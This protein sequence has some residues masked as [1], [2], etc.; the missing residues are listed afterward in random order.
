MKKISKIRWNRYKES[1]QGQDAIALFNQLAAPECT[2]EEMIQAA[3]KYDPQLFYNI[4]EK[5][6]ESLREVID[7]YLHGMKEVIQK[8]KIDFKT[9]DDCLDFYVGVLY[10]TTQHSDDMSFEDI[11][12]GAF[13]RSVADNIFISL[14][15]YNAIGKFF[16]PNFFVM[17]F[18]YLKKFAEK[19]EI[20]L[21]DTPK[22]ADYK[23]RCLFYYDI[24]DCFNEF[25]QENEF[26]SW[27][28]F[29]AFLYD[30]E[31]PEIKEE[32]ENEDESTMPSVPQQAW[33]LVGNYGEGERDMK[34]GFWQ[35]NELTEKGDLLL[36]Y[37]KSP[38]MAMNS[39]WISQTHGVVDPFFARYSNTYIGQKIDIPAEYALT[40][41][42]FKA[43]EYFQNKGSKGNFVS[44]NFQDCSGWPVSNDDFK[45]I[46]RM[47]EAKGFDTSKIP[48][49]YEPEKI[50]DVDIKVEQDV[51]DLR[52][53]PMLEQMG[54]KEGV[55]FKPEMQFQA[56]RGT[57]GADINKR[58]DFALH[59]IDRE[60]KKSARVVIECKLYMKNGN[61]INDA[62][63][64]GE[65]YAKWGNARVMV[66]C[67]KAQIRVYKRNKDGEFSS[68]KYIKFTWADTEN[69]D[70]FNELKRLLS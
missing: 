55:D 27:A 20:D 62:F 43:S 45:E 18:I 58:V 35:A 15:L 38:V 31:L 4:S 69:A 36:F 28:E 10:A 70:K 3:K 48:H 23:E 16:I 19:Y 57:T 53:V 11:P 9:T 54:W 49:L 29:C 21:P 56:G 6:C 24:C 68:S 50:G 12:T 37:E 60:D 30:L 7:F 63:K 44:K 39:I 47:L 46:L 51:S 5:E 33:L 22:K 17:Q 25:K 61:E 64:Q 8:E 32:L 41:K 14:A 42:D 1:H 66:L 2:P 13:K 26:E 65:S 59:Y 52:L 67:D 40:I 34:L